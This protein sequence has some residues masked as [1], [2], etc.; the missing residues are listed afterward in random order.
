MRNVARQEPPHHIVSLEAQGIVDR[1]IPVIVEGV[2]IGA[3]K[4]RQIVKDVNVAAGSCF[5]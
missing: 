5:E 4:L 2:E 1:S 3:W